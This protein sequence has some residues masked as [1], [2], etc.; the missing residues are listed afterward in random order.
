MADSSPES[1]LVVGPCRQET[2]GISQF[3]RGQAEELGDRLDV[4]V[5]NTSTPP[6]RGAL[7]AGGLA[8]VRWLAVAALSAIA[9]VV[10]FPLYLD[11]DVVHV[12]ASSRVSF[13]R[14]SVY[15]MLVRLLRDVPLVIHIHGSDFDAFLQ[16]AGPLRRAYI[17]TIFD[18]CSGVIVL[19]EYWANVLE[20][21]LDVSSISVVPNPVD[22]E[23]FVPVYDVDP[24]RIVYVSNLIDRK[25]VEEFV[26]AIRRL[27]SWS[28]L[29]FTVDIA[30]RGPRSDLV[31]DLAAEFDAV[32]YHGFVSEAEKRALLDEGSI[33]VLPTYAEGL[34]ISLL[35]GM[36]GGNAIVST[37]VGSI[38]EV[39]GPDNG[40]LVDPVD[41]DDLVEALGA[42]IRDDARRQAMG[43]T[44]RAAIEAEHTWAHISDRLLE[45]Y[46][47][48]TDGDDPAPDRVA[49]G[50]QMSD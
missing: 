16:E 42:L 13:Y 40:H 44:N 23:R 18:Q 12:H 29:E 15:I 46:G 24:P 34:P 9:R 45:T 50:A 49:L 2:G 17:Q 14:K 11:A 41:V 19:S 4:T 22:A 28:D 26:T 39:V 43:R 37:T 38:P 48:L 31:T 36:A 21:A 47:G 3:I 10:L 20:E 35:E 7:S 5:Y 1:L 6:E 25:G 32:E 30:G 27:L 33:Y 8:K